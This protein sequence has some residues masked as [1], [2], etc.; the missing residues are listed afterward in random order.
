MNFPTGLRILIISEGLQVGEVLEQVLNAE[1]HTVRVTQNAK[2]VLDGILLF[3]PHIVILETTEAPTVAKS[4]RNIAAL[5]RPF[6]LSISKEN[7]VPGPENG[8]E[9]RPENGP[10]SKPSSEF[11]LQLSLPL[12]RKQFLGL[13]RRMADIVS[14]DPMI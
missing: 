6:M 11:D 12:D 13:F 3:Q 5:H 1:G 7:P 4:I 9:N 10:E 8:L 2:A 14:F